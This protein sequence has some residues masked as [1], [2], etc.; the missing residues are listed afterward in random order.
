MDL[1]E[2]EKENDSEISETDFRNKDLELQ[3]YEKF[4]PKIVKNYN[5]NNSIKNTEDHV[6][7]LLYIFLKNYENE[8]T[9]IIDDQNKA[10]KE[11]LINN[12]KNVK[13]GSLS[14][15]INY[16]SMNNKIINDILP[17]QNIN[18]K[19]FNSN[20]SIINLKNNNISTKDEKYM[21]KKRR[22]GKKVKLYYLKIGFQKI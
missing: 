17:N 15:N 2:P 3:K 11:M 16:E 9:Y 8:N 14:I 13:S 7:N 20:R 21:A 19:K 4:K 5:K 22:F 6:K 12:K 10:R 1:I 18:N